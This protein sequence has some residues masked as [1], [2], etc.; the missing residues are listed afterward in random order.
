MMT[1]VPCTLVLLCANI[2]AEELTRCRMTS[3][4]T[5]PLQLHSE[6]TL[7]VQKKVFAQTACYTLGNKSTWEKVPGLQS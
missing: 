1:P 5:L 2:A 4:L 6:P 3:Q 7:Q